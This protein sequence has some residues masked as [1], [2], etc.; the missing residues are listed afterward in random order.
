MDGKL[1]PVD[2]KFV[3]ISEEN[4]RFVLEKDDL[5]MAR[6]GATY[7]KTMI[8]EENY[9]AVF[10][11][12]LIK[13]SFDKRMIHPKYYWH[14]AQSELFWNQANKLV[15]GGG[16]PQF[17]ANA[18]KEVIIPIPFPRD[19]DKSVEEQNRIISILDKF[20]NLTLSST[21]GL[22]REIELRKKQYEYYRNMLLSFPKKKNR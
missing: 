16:Q 6:T 8:F 3:D 14:F 9:A 15:S 4:S 18:V 11:G 19:P 7:G 1:I 10:A 13:I 12:F 22:K 5:L 20:D 17:N 21:E 2:P